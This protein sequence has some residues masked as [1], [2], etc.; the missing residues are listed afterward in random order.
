MADGQVTVGTKQR[1]SRGQRQL[2]GLAWALLVGAAMAGCRGEHDPEA[3]GHKTEAAAAGSVSPLDEVARVHGGA[4]PWAVAGY[5]M[6]SFALTKLG[7]PR[8][9]FDLDVTHH[10]PLSPQY[11]C[12]ADGASASTGASIGKV[13]LHLVEADAKAMSTTY[14]RKSTGQEI[15]LRPTEAFKQRFLDVPRP[16]LM[17]AGAQVLTLKD[18]EIF[19]EI[20]P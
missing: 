10:S 13:N 2:G 11:A 4:G 3:H 9:S 17:E 16:K 6:G 7:L 8:Q 14:K 12:I 18:E 15:T 1:A 19:E 20:K 5:R